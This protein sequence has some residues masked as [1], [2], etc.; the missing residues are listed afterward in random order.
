MASDFPSPSVSFL[1]FAG[2][3]ESVRQLVRVGAVQAP[4]AQP[5]VRGRAGEAP[6]LLHLP[7][8]GKQGRQ[9]SMQSQL[10]ISGFVILQ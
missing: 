3:S 4:P 10:Q 6:R 8:Q 7:V 2:P 9:V 1:R 5:D